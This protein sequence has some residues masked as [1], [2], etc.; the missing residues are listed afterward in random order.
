MGEFRRNMQDLVNNPRG[1]LEMIADRLQNASKGRRAVINDQGAGYRNLT[2]QERLQAVQQAAID[3]LGGGGL[4]IIKAKG[5]NWLTGSVENALK[6]LKKPSLGDY[7]NRYPNQPVPE[8]MVQEFLPNT[9]LNNWIEGPL[10]KYVKRDMATEGDPVRKLAEQGVLHFEP[11]MQSMYNRE[12]L[13]GVRGRT[14][15]LPKGVASSDLAKSWENASDLS[16]DPTAA[17]LYRGNPTARVMQEN[18]WL[19]KLAPEDMV[20]EP[21]TNFD[22]DLGLSHLADELAN[23]LN[24]ESGLPRNL[25]LTPEQM[26]Q[27]GMEKA[28]R[29]V[30]AINKWRAAQKVE[31]NA[32]LAQSPAVHM[33]R[34]YAENNPKGLR[35]VE[36]KQPDTIDFNPTVGQTASD[37][38]ALKDEQGLLKGKEFSSEQEAIDSLS[39]AEKR[40]YLADQLKY[41]GDTMGHCVGGYCDEVADGR[42]R[43]FSLRDAKGEPH[44]TIET[45]PYSP[46][47]TNVRDLMKAAGEQEGQ[48]IWK[49]YTSSPE[50][51]NM[52]LSSY[53]KMKHPE[54]WDKIYRGLDSI[55]QIKGKANL[56]PK[57]EYLPFVQDFVK[58]G[59]WSDVGDLSNTGLFRTDKLRKGATL[60][61]PEADYQALHKAMYQ[62]NP[63][64]VSF[65]QGLSELI[66]E[67]AEYMTRDELMNLIKPKQNFASGGSVKSNTTW[68]PMELDGIIGYITE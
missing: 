46:T 7:A 48:A 49:E 50:S 33:V 29:H 62:A 32:K 38:W 22:R 43:I 36:L 55:V 19:S 34:E 18:P 57:E 66:P 20:Y 45:K 54:A 1:Y 17:S 64:L 44:V 13:E 51:V 5:G 39:A 58:S 4:G 42:S 15:N 59:K 21:R 35:W 2:Q 37:K 52:G 9:A 26:Q 40:R 3:N 60:G 30:D 68:R 10:T 24:P 11:P 28:V 47:S 6:G 61:L 14:G 16:I 23:A 8:A 12:V 53:L 65:S 31:A 25:Q 67:G 56:A 63:D 41:E 27:L